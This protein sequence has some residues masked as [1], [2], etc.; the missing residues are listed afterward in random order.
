MYTKRLRFHLRLL[1][2]PL[3]LPLLLRLRRDPTAAS[4][5]PEAH[6][7]TRIT[8]AA[9]VGLSNSKSE[10]SKSLGLRQ[11]RLLRRERLRRR[12]KWELVDTY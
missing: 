1:R 9:T 5:D 10:R 7:T 2:Q 12:P 4:K 3:L 11:L 8:A 6:P